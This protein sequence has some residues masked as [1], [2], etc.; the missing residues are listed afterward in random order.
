V[1]SRKFSDVLR[2]TID[3]DHD[4]VEA[5]LSKFMPLINRRSLVGGV[6]DEDL[7]QYILMRVIIQIPKFDPDSTK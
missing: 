7:R 5:I 1:E 4:S 2:K 3:G 6:L